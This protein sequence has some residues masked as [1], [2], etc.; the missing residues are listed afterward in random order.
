MCQMMEQRVETD[1]NAVDDALDSTFAGQTRQPT[2]RPDADFPQWR[3]FAPRLWRRRH[4][5]RIIF[6]VSVLLWSSEKNS[7]RNDDCRDHRSCREKQFCFHGPISFI[8]E[9]WV[10]EESPF[11]S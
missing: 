5:L 11:T 1:V 7:R 3:S 4:F 2:R 10:L 6:F 9:A 8:A